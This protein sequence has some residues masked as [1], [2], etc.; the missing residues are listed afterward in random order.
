[1]EDFQLFEQVEVEEGKEK[2]EG[3]RKE[4]ERANGVGYPMGKVVVSNGN[5]VRSTYRSSRATTTLPHIT[6]VSVTSSTYC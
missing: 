2:L 5:G 6:S 4:L 3:K 1:M